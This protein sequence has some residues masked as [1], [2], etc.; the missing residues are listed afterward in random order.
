[1]LGFK[2]ERTF[3]VW[4]WCVS[5][6]QLLLRSARNQNDPDDSN[7]DLVFAGVFYMELPNIIRG[8][9]IVQP[10]PGDD[11]GRV[12]APDGGQYY[13]LVT[14]KRRFI[15]GA[16]SLQIMENKLAFL[17]SSLDCGPAK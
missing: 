16:V 4:D 9:E 17:E 3:R 1:M 8:V 15:V 2:S 7:L 12:Q 14:E 13:V 10:L 6:S 11:A 5:H